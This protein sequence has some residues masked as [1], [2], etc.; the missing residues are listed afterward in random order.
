MYKVI[1]EAKGSGARLGA[2]ETPHGK[3]ETPFFMPVA[4]KASVKTLSP[5]EIEGT[6]SQVLIS[7]AFVLHLEPGSEAICDMGGLHKFMN[8]NGGLFTDSGGF[9][10][11]RHEFE[12]VLKEEGVQFRSPFDGTKHLMTPELVME[13]QKNLGSDIAMVLDDCPEHGSSVERVEKAVKRTIAWAKQAKESHS[14]KGQLLFAITQGGID[15]GM[16]RN[17]TRQLVEIGFDG[18]GIGGLSIGEPDEDMYRMLE[19]SDDELPRDSARYLMGLGSPVQILEAV[20]RGVDIFDSVFPTR[21]ARHRS[22]FTSTGRLNVKRNSFQGKNEPIEKGCDC[23]T[24]RNFTKAYIFHLIRAH[25]MLGMRL[26]T[27][28]NLRYIQKFMQG[29]RNSL[30]EGTFAEFK[31]STLKALEQ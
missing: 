27:I 13:I 25:E 24:C 14:A 8:W 11:L 3:F 22:V 6:G 20:D 30:R 5:E 9:Q 28:H 12:P 31:R 16:R 4:T 17:C 2:V 10:I 18:Y 26:L 7:N 23:Y 29:I 15:D 19:I 1:K 21:N